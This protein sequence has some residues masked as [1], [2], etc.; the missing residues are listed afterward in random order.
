MRLADWNTVD[1]HQL[2]PSD[3]VWKAIFFVGKGFQWGG[4]K[5]GFKNVD[6]LE[7]EG[8]IELRD[9]VTSSIVIDACPAD[10][11]SSS[12]TQQ[13]MHWANVP[14]SLEDWRRYVSPKS[15]LCMELI[16]T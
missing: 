1:L 14:P 5:D 3:G 6:L 15:P 9:R 12:V 11:S 2:A 7:L 16:S 13:Q 10:I 4:G 8:W